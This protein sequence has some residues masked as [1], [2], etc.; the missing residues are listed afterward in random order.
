M[1]VLGAT[2][3]E[4]GVLSKDLCIGCGACI[5]LCPYFQTF[6]GKTAQLFA[7]TVEKGRCFAYCPKI[8][9][10]LDDL[11]QHYFGKPYEFEPIGVYR[12]IKKSKAG[13]SA[14]E[15]GFQCGGTVSALMSFAL[16]KGYLDA[17]ILTDKEELLPV[18]RIVTDS[19]AVTSYASSKYTAAPTLSALN[20]AIKEDYKNIG[21]VGTPCQV[22]SIAQLRLNPTE[23]PDFSDPV[24]FVMGLFCTWSLDYRAFSSF[25]T[26]YAEIDEITKIDIPPPPAEV[27]EIYTGNGKIEIPLSEIRENIPNSCDYCIDM[28]SEFSDISVGV[29][30]GVSDMN[31]LI[32][33]TERGQKLVND[34]VTAGY[35]EIDDMP[36]ENKEHLFEASGNKKK[37]ALKRLQEEGLLNTEE[38][39]KCATFRVN[40]KI[41]KQMTT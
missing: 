28:T 38:E 35:L 39:G 11:S 27:M 7:C 19:E 36:E 10:N 21:V 17:A 14:P 18:P 16:S 1:K 37:R 34:A 40:D 15:G 31:T 32:I 26:R 30:E 41:I 24:K 6:R 2:E 29:L 8:E 22:L 5:E 33:R 3:L 4:L 20:R 12:D 23:I 9:V 25:I 13:K